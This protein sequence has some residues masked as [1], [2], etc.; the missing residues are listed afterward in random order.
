MDYLN[1]M[2]YT[3]ASQGYWTMSPLIF[4]A[5]SSFTR[6]FLAS[7]SGIIGYSYVNSNS[8]VRPVINL[9]AN[10]EITAGIGTKNDPFIVK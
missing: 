3:Y 8:G 9:K 10:T 7:D 1:K 5:S 2:S 6:T 4:N